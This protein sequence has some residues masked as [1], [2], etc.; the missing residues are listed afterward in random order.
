MLERDRFYINGQWVASAGS[1]RIDVV[2][3]ATEEQIARVAAASAEDVDRAVAAAEAASSGWAAKT[4]A[5]RGDYLAR[6]VER[7]RAKT[8]ELVRVVAMDIGMPVRLAKRM[9]VQLPI[10]IL[11]SYVGYAREYRTEER[12]GNSLVTRTPVGVVACI[13][14]W[15]YPL[16]QIA[17]KIGP[18]LIAGCTVVLKPSE[19]APLVTY[20]LAEAVDEAGLPPGVFNLL[21]GD[22]SAGAALVNHAKVRAISFT[23][24][25]AAGEKI[26]ETAARQLKRVALELG[27]KSPSLLLDDADFALA[28]KSTVSSCFLNSGQTCLALTRMLVP[29]S[30][31]QEAAELAVAATRK[32][33][34]GAPDD[35]QAKLGPLVS[36]VQQ[37]RVQ[38]YIR[39]GIEEGATLLVG[40][41]GRPAGF[42]RG[43]YVQPT[44]FGEV[45]PESTIARE[46]IFGPVLSIIPYQDE[47][48][49]I[50]IANGT[51]YGLS[52]AVWSKSDERAFAVARQI[53]S[54]QVEVN[55]GAFNLAAPFGGLKKS[56]LGKELGMHAIDEFVEIKSIQLPEQSALLNPG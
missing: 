42:A 51:Q 47:A 20:L 30:R 4:M 38:A 43:Y 15:N 24:S 17:T 21:M 12:I 31:Y 8:D 40:G 52:G 45:S 10:A 19:V 9:Q 36:A 2:N 29:R 44:V 55:G 48:E 28:V 53:Q 7:L 26:G 54:G 37:S 16:F 14:P 33:T 1:G 34:L 56:G 5:E 11:E 25:T 32:L 41:A 35:E 27:G 50:R 23:G 18:A 6:I 22:A 13:T 3:P 39:K 46:E 49:A